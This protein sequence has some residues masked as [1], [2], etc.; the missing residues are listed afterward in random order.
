M[1]RENQESF[2]SV[3]NDLL[4]K[5]VKV[6]GRASKN[7]M[8]DRLEFVAN[9]VNINPNPDEE[10]KKLDEEVSKATVSEEKIGAE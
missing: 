2:G 4:G 8:F 1:F 6:V 10:I 5:I 3:K 9:R 7:Q